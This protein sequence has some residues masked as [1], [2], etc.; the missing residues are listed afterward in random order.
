MHEMVCLSDQT[1][2]Q[3]WLT[4]HSVVSE[5]LN[6]W[7]SKVVADQILTSGEDLCKKWNTFADLTGVLANKRLKLSNW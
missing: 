7:V 5:M 1:A 4:E 3:A 2:K 6:P